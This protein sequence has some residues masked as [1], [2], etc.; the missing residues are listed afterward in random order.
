[1]KPMFIRLAALAFILFS[2]Q[3]IFAQDPTS[4]VVRGAPQTYIVK[5]GDTLWEIACK[6][7]ND[8]WR[9]Q[10]VWC[11][12]PAIEN[13][14]RIYAGDKLHLDF[15]EGKPRIRV[16]RGHAWEVLDK[17]TGVIKLLPRV[18]DLPAD[19]EI[20]TIAMHVITPFFNQSRVINRCQ[21]LDSPEIVSLEEAHIGAGAGD[22]VFVGGLSERIKDDIFSVVRPGRRYFDP[23][24]KADLGIEGIVVGQ[25]ERE[26][27]GEL[28]RWLVTESST[29]IEAGDKL[30]PTLDETIDTFFV[31]R[32]PEGEAG[33]KIISV[34]DGFSQI[35]QFQVIVVTGGSDKKRQHGDVLD[36]IHIQEKK[37]PW[38][39]LER[40][41]TK[42]YCHFPSMKI[43]RCLVF[44][45]FD[46][47]SYALVMYATHPIYLLDS[48]NAP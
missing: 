30:L 5:K 10:E 44:R 25:V 48:V 24:T 26:V 29:S 14:N 27:G 9:W 22:R 2:Q 23:D 1:M 40:S 13:P 3:S 8:P 43:G 20:P 38:P 39:F 18:R 15:I 17:R 28:S 32:F 4:W 45:V 35:G 19:Q 7:L 41:E 16:E 42:N 31:P 47:V 46:K 6:F 12:N 36:I 34:F 11:A 33:G 37:S 21:A